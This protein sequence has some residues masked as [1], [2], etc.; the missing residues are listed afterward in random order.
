MAGR[1]PRSFHMLRNTPCGRVR[2]TPET[3]GSRDPGHGKPPPKPHIRAP[4]D[5]EV[6]R[7]G[8]VVG[9][10]HDVPT[11]DPLRSRTIRR[12]EKNAENAFVAG[13]ENSFSR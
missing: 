13:P 2:I 11:H 9:S 7:R 4:R 12:A 1:L 10:F 6:R 8:R 3:F 5:K